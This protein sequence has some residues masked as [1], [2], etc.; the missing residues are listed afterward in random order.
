MLVNTPVFST[1]LF[2]PGGFL[3]LISL[4]V[5]FGAWRLLWDLSP[6]FPVQSRVL[7]QESD[8]LRVFEPWHTSTSCKTI[9]DFTPV[10]KEL[11]SRKSGLEHMSPT[12][13]SPH[14]TITCTPLLLQIGKK[15]GDPC[16]CCHWV[17]AK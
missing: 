9:V 7:P 15:P 17:A 12:I 11:R 13:Q 4:F 14:L 6:W 5:V 3:A 10:S 1:L 2:S 8:R 16:L